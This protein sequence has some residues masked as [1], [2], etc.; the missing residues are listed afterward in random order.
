M[1]SIIA[2][3]LSKTVSTNILQVKHVGFGV[4]TVTVRI[5]LFHFLAL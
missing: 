2:A 4:K 1:P 5:Q 3:L